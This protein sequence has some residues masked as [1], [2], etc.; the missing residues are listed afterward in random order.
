MNYMTPLGLAHIM[1]TGP[2]LRARARGRDCRTR[3]LDA[4][5][6]H[7]ADTLGIGFDRTADG[8][9]RGRTVFSAACAIA[10]PTRD[11][12]RL[13]AAVV[14]SRRLDATRMRSGRTLWDE[15]VAHYHAGV[16]TVR[17]MRRAWAFVARA[18][19]DARAS[20]R[21]TIVPRDSGAGGALVA[22]RGASVL[23]DVL[24][25]A[26]SGGLRAAGASAGVLP[27]AFRCPAR[28]RKPRCAQSILMNGDQDRFAI[29]AVAQNAQ[30]NSD[31]PAISTIAM[32]VHSVH[33][34]PP[35]STMPRL[36]R[37]APNTTSPSASGPSA[38]SAAIRSATPCARRLSPTRHR[39]EAGRARR[40]RR[41]P[42]R[43]RSRAARRERRRARSHRARVQGGARRNRR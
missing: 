22:R 13:A 3:R 4:V 26:D 11:R 33:L 30:L 14:P 12:S 34:A 35:R 5:Y 25:T 2:S 1:A 38:T 20:P 36:R 39:R 37:R 6:Y 16:D 32:H 21:W 43:Q 10:T 19:I 24:A 42:P 31:G 29:D 8:Q 23:P 27:A 17:S 15:L 28:S 18:S 9:Q 40:V 41:Q 7:R